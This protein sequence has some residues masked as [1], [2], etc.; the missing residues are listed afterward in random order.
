M[1]AVSVKNRII[2]VFIALSAAA[3]LFFFGKPA[4][5]EES[6]A[7]NYS[8]VMYNNSN[9]LPTSEANDIVQ[10]NDGFIYIGSYSGLIRYD[11]VNFTRF[12]SFTGI[13]SVVSLFI[14][15]KNRLWIGTNDSGLALYDNGAFTFYNREN[16]LSSLSVRDITEDGAGNIIF[17]TTSELAYINEQGE[18]SVIDN[19]AI[20]GKYFKQ[21]TADKNGAV[22]GCTMD[23]DFFR[24]ENLEITAH[25]SSEE[26]GFGLVTCIAPDEYEAGMVWLG[27]DKSNIICGNISDKMLNFRVIN[28]EP[29]SNINSITAIDENSFWVCSDSGIGKLSRNGKYTAEN[30]P[31]NNSVEKAMTDY[32]NNIWFVSSRQ[33]VMKLVKNNFTDISAAAGLPE[34]VVNTTCLFNGDLYIGTD[35]GLYI[36]GENN[37]QKS[38][39]LTEILKGARIR[40][41]IT[42][43]Q[44]KLWICSYGVNGILRYDGK[45]LVSFNSENGLKSQKVRDARELADGTIAAAT[46]AGIA[47]IKDGKIEGFIDEESGIGNAEILTICGGDNGKIY[48]GSDGSGIFIVE[49]GKAVKQIGLEDGLKSEIIMRIKPDEKRGGYWIITGNSLAY[50]KDESVKT[51]A[52]FPYSNN[53]DIFTDNSDEAWILSSS[54]IYVV[55]AE[56]LISGEEIEYEFFDMKCGIPAIATANSRSCL[57]EDGTLYIAGQTGVAAVNI[58]ERREN[59]SEIKL[60]VPYVDIDDKRVLIKDG[61]T[62]KIPANCKRLTIYGYALTFGFSNPRLSYCLEGFDADK[63]SVT[64]QDLQPISYTNLDS[65]E[66]TFKFSIIDITTGESTATVSVKMEKEKA[67]FEQFWFWALIVFGVLAVGMLAMLIIMNIKNRRLK[68]REEENR[69]FVDQIIRAFAKCIDLKDT[70]T[71]GH[72]FRVARYTAMIAERMGYGKEQVE[73]IYNIGLLHDIGKIAVPDSILGKPSRLT[74]EEFEVIRH[75]AENGYKILKEIE[76]RPELAIGAGYH[77]EYYDGSGYPSGLK[78]EEIP[79][80]AQ[81]ITV[82]D[83]FDA[84]NS[85]RAYRKQMSKDDILAEMRRISGKQLNPKIVDVFFELVDEGKFN[86]VFYDDT[87]ESID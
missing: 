8:A 49:N 66:Y 4:F 34:S 43:S 74:N 87:D 57:S 85:T 75:H 52:N 30:Y 12:D 83:T 84:M 11:G 41:I 36:V 27:T 48:L 62:L 59:G 21:L 86:D 33:G 14:D 71:N 7:E 68:R 69:L 76:I 29:A 63:I 54:G 5:A 25:Y 65:G 24:M 23:G 61:E 3:A 35:S 56:K 72:S 40:C 64:R 22:Y 20:N 80:I 67:F 38:N 79:E 81:I 19:E 15:S 2:A 6:K 77:H 26:M 45:N 82:A 16:G 28:A 55:N 13:T 73:D 70:Y 32:E 31:L 78:G 50:M 47:L 42:D 53:F 39:E 44:N 37:E 51:L 58:N 46:S 60:C 18:L 1:R 10:T 9:G 17:G